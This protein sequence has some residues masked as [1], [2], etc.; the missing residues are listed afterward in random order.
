[1][2]TDSSKYK[3]SLKYKLVFYLYTKSHLLY[4]WN[5][6][7]KSNHSQGYESNFFIYILNEMIVR[8]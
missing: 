8:F 6:K 5:E 1:M 3:C 2:F 7:K 4:V